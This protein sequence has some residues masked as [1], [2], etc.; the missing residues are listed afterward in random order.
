MKKLILFTLLFL[1][2]ISVF[3]ETDSRTFTLEQDSQTSWSA[4]IIFT[5]NGAQNIESKPYGDKVRSFLKVNNNLY[6][7]IISQGHAK[8]KSG[9]YGYSFYLSHD[10]DGKDHIQELNEPAHGFTPFEVDAF[11]FRNSDNTGSNELGLKNVNAAG[12]TR[13]VEFSGYR[14]TI[15]TLDAN[16]INLGQGEIPTFNTVKF[17]VTISKNA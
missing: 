14:M 11:H 12:A 17:L 6:L 16:I 9:R 3:A 5:E 10:I 4:Y 2:W 8:A 13:M 1:P 7:Q 15:R